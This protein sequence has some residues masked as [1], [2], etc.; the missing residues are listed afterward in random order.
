MVEQPPPKRLV[1]VRFLPPL[2]S[3]RPSERSERGGVAREAVKRAETRDR[4]LPPL[5]ADIKRIL[6]HAVSAPC[7]GSER[8]AQEMSADVL[9]K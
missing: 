5:P 1:R 8:D 6:V 4:F 2:P 7:H 9:Y 3:E